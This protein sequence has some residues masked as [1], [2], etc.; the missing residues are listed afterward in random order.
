MQ[1]QHNADIASLKDQIT[2]SKAD[3]AA[4]EI[5]MT[6][7]RAAS[8]AQ[9]QRIQAEN[10]RLLMDQ[11]A[12][13]ELFKRR[14]RPHLPADYNAMNLFGTPG[15]GTSNHAALNWTIVPRTGAPDQPQVMGPPP[16]TD[17]PRRYTTRPPGHFSTP[18]DN[19]IAAASRLAAIPIE[20]ESPA[21][22]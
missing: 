4:E 22:I 7:E 19:M 13:N 17:N 3:L 9:A 2:Q 1:D 20:G 6:E 11:N 10:Y 21:A 16:R 5:R 18:L 8:D 14:H 15:A 12:S